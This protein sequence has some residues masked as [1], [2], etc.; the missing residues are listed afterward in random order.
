V[1]GLRRR[2][3]PW[4]ACVIVA[5]VGIP[6][7]AA[8]KGNQGRVAPP[9][10]N[11]TVVPYDFGFRD[12]TKTKDDPTATTVTIAPGGRV[13]F[14][15]P[16]G[17]GANQ[18]NVVFGDAD[19]PSASLP[20]PTACT[21][22]AA[23]FPVGPTNGPAPL[24]TIALGPPWAG[25]CTFNTAGVYKFY[26][27]VHPNMRAQ[28]VVTATG[29]NTPPTVTAS[30][31]P[32]G[33]VPNGTAIAFTAIGSDAD[34][35]PITYAWDFGDGDTATGATA[36]HTYPAP[37]SYTATVT[38]ADNQ[39]GT[40]SATV[41]VTVVASTNHAPTV[42]AGRTP[43]GTIT[44]GTAVNFTAAGTDSDG[45]PLTYAWEFGDGGTSTQQNPTHTFATTGTF[46]A[47]VTV[48]DGKGGNGS[49]TLSV[50]VVAP[51]QNPTVSITRN[52]TG[53]V[54]TG[55]SVAFTATASD[56]DADPLTYT[57]DFGDS[58]SSTQQNPSHSYSTA[59]TYSAKVTVSDGHGGTATSN[60]LTIVV[61]QANR[62]PTASITRTPTGNIVSGTAV[63]FTTTA[64]DPDGDTLTY[65]W[66][67]G[68]GTAASSAQ[69]PTHT[70]TGT[71]T[72]S[73]KV[74]VN[75]GH[76]G[77]VTS[78][79]L[80]ITVTDG[81]TCPPGFRDDFNGTALDASWSV[82]RPDATDGGI[83]VG[84]GTVAIPTG[85]GDIYQTT[86]TATNIVLRTAP[87]GAFTVTAK[88]NH[89]GNER[90]QQGGI[91]V[92]GD[93]DNYVKLDRTGTNAPTSTNTEFFEFI[94]EQAGT[95][96]NATQDH[97]ANL[98]AGFPS[99]FYLRIIWDG[100]NLTGAYSTDGSAWTTVGRASTAMPANPKIGFFALSNGATTVVSPKFDYLTIDG[101]PCGTNQNPVIS[102]A[103]ADKT[104]GVAS[105]PVNFTAAA[106]DPDGDPLTYAWDFGDG[107]T[108]TG[109]TATHTYTT[110]G[111]FSAKLTVSD[112]KNGSATRTIPITALPQD[113]A[114][115]AF[116]TLVFSKT[117]AFRHDSI[118]QGIAAIKNLGTQGNFQV[119]ATE[120]G[121]VFRDDILSHYKTV[122]FLSTTGD[123]LTDDQQAAFERFIR[124]G[125]GYVGIHSAADTEYTWPWY[126][127][128]VGAYFRDHP[129]GTPQANVLVEDTTDPSDAGLP[130]IWQRTDEWYNFQP[131]VNPVVNGGTT[132]TP[133]N[134]RDNTALH[135]LLKM[136]TSSYTGAAPSGSDHPI[137]WCHRFDGGRSWYTGMG[138]TQASF[139]EA[140]VLSHILAGIKITA[141]VLSS[142]ACGVTGSNANPSVTATR[143]PTGNVATG[144]SVAFTAT[145]TDPDGDPLTYSW[146]F[147]DGTPNSTQPNPSHAY[148]TAGTYTATVTVSD[149]KGGTG[150]APLTVVVTQANRNPTVTVSRNPAGSV[151]PGTPIAF[152]AAAAD[153]DG[154]TLTYA[155]EFGDSGTSNV[156]NPTH[157]YAAPGTYTAKVTVTD[158]KGGSGTDTV[159][160]GVNGPTQDHTDAPQDVMATVPTLL[161]LDLAP[162]A[163]L[164]A[165]VP[166]V[167][168]DYT[169]SVAA[170]VTSTAGNA[171]L[172]ISDAGPNAPGH[173]V[174]GT[175][176]LASPVEAQATNA[177]QTS[178]AFS[179][180]GA[181]PVTL[182]SYVAPVSSDVVNVG[183][184]QHV[185]GAELLRAGTYTKTLTF[186]LTTT[187][188]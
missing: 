14:N 174:N 111:T 87:S 41:P 8:A 60:T 131:Y 173:L 160:V 98:A 176:A 75:D 29:A 153:A 16:V 50:T 112:G 80:S 163:A 171:A 67:F 172:A 154:D 82:L 185:S 101:P 88:I 99:D 90:Y 1:L 124:A 52:P 10:M 158:G 2:Q 128:L 149:G 94:Q 81:T 53:N 175:Y 147:G 105:L 86:N 9:P 119:D 150:S 18:H 100:T 7:L 104:I 165:I 115:A 70:Y 15:Y 62:N 113:T 68:D 97:T 110:G 120:D 125:N 184:R 11:A 167:A 5:L 156:Q 168:H 23:P 12:A 51:N 182:L 114:G 17:D 178:A 144:T 118:P 64:S 121:S 145:G 46:A 169:A 177:T 151:D 59:G 28:V 123:V 13:D 79:T 134:P 126:G 66:D 96:R 127:Q 132:A 27:Q 108:A 71:G 43:T 180:V 34:G 143:N 109:A 83:V 139:S 166:G 42:T 48:S 85:V 137:S 122:I 38:A 116:R 6:A 188:P 106:T 130:A 133:Y 141:G 56:P 183:F 95:A 155:W 93:D 61:T 186:T 35:D 47:K 135:I 129:N 140:G 170:Q 45:D 33:N 20:Q 159:V 55:T 102:S 78:N 74:T 117:A 103:T 157:T 146:N 26:C 107:G 24:P 49:D 89:H 148:T 40:K 138:H 73:A 39:G 31:N 92:Y 84:G 25:F 44:S 19:N 30:R 152:T 161:R 3:L 181:S 58:A 32:T 162:S 37:G 187:T 54:T 179:A 76:G 72:Y 21:L 142:S 77:T 36:S 57:W 4:L 136:D 22:T 164:G 69:N 63:S 65:T 91:I